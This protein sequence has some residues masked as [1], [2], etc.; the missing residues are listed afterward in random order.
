MADEILAVLCKK[1]PG[2]HYPRL[3]LQPQNPW[4]QNRGAKK[5]VF[6]DLKILL[7]KQH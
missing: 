4:T 5:K 2:R 1:Q 7:T 3:S 6:L